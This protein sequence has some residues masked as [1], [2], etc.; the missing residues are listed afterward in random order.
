MGN[1]KEQETEGSM[2]RHS[3]DDRIDAFMYA[4]EGLKVQR[5]RNLRRHNMRM[6][7]LAIAAIAA[8]VF[9]AWATS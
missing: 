6:I 4:I 9:I 3:R 7:A 2:T 1:I 8:G 5:A